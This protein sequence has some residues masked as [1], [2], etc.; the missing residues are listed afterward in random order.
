MK[1]IYPKEEVCVNCHLCQ[2]WCLVEHSKSKD[3]LKAYKR[4]KDRPIPRVHVEEKGN[5]SFAVQC[6]HCKEPVCV[7]SCITGAMTKDP[8]TGVVTV[9]SERCIGCWTCVLVC[10]YGAPLP[11]YGNEHVVKCDLCP[12]RQTPV[13]VENCPNEA[14]IYAEEPVSG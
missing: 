4:E 5:I 3:I 13:C 9:D 11:D 7:Y 12:G 14:L 2:V 1:K 8:V 6:R 10:P